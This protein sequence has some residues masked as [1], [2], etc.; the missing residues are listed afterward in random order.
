VGIGG[1]VMTIARARG[2]KGLKGLKEW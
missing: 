2:L 1:K